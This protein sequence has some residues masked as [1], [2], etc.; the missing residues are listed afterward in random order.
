MFVP[1]IMQVQVITAIG[2]VVPAAKYTLLSFRRF[3]LTLV[4]GCNSLV[5]YNVILSTVKICELED[6]C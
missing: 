4:L 2:L 3:A 1:M 5:V 6:L